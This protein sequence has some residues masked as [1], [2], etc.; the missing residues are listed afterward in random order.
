MG[1]FLQN[2]NSPFTP[3]FQSIESACVCVCVC[4]RLPPPQQPTQPGV[5]AALAKPRELPCSA[6]YDED[7]HPPVQSSLPARTKPS[8][9][10]TRVCTRTHTCTCT[11]LS[12]PAPLRPRRGSGQDTLLW[13][14]LESSYSDKTYMHLATYAKREMRRAEPSRLG[15]IRA[16][17]RM[18]AYICRQAL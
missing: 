12:S 11:R 3:L 17:M 10:Q 5:P 8:R 2:Q 6:T 9:Q 18:H 7:L 14:G 15:E 4:Q 1:R 16:C 13:Q